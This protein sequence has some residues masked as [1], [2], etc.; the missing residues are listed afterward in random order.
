MDKKTR[1]DRAFQKALEAWLSAEPG[2]YK[3]GAAYANLWRKT[4]TCAYMAQIKRSSKG[5]PQT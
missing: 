1:K 3:E 2:S 4:N 5:L